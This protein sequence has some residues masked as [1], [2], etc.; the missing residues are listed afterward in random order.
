MGG[1]GEE[2]SVRAEGREERKEESRFERGRGRAGRSN[3]GE[4]VVVGFRDSLEER[5]RSIEGE[6]CMSFEQRKDEKEGG[7]RRRNGK[8]VV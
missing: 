8:V 6:R 5:G 1:G 7:R 2:G 3:L 4:E